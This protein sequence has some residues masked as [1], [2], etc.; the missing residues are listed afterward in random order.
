MTYA[1]EIITVKWHHNRGYFIFARHLGD[2]H[3][4]DVPDGSLFEDVP[5]YN[6]AEMRPLTGEDGVSHYDIFVF[7]P[8][9]MSRLAENHFTERQ[10]VKL[11][12]M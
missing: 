11:T 2:K 9:S 10:R 1:F 3:D 7:R 4:F 8:V 5:I 6:Y 12:T